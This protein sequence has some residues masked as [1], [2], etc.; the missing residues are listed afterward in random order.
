MPDESP[1][2]GCDS[3]REFCIPHEVDGSLESWD[4][5][6]AVMTQAFQAGRLRILCGGVWHDAI[7]ECPHC[8][9]QFDV[10]VETERGY[11]GTWGPANRRP[12]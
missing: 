7:L 5:N 11:F 6:L 8:G 1:S 12:R 3:C 9:Q 4:K 10:N 2:I